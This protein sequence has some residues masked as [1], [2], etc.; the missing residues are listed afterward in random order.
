MKQ[1]VTTDFTGTF[2]LLLTRY[3]HG[4]L[5][6][7]LCFPR[8]SCRDIKLG[9]FLCN[10][11]RLH[12]AGLWPPQHGGQRPGEGWRGRHW[13]GERGI[14]CS[15]SPRFLVLMIRPRLRPSVCAR[16]LTMYCNPICN[17]T[18]WLPIYLIYLCRNLF[19]SSI[20]NMTVIFIYDFTGANT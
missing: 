11:Q 4:V 5:M 20:E 7:S 13:L 15:A 14:L 17:Y 12:T 6:F 2:Q 9:Q 1:Y 18:H 19:F 3:F 8:Q 16:T 10:P